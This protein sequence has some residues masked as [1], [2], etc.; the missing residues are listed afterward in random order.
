MKI[1]K[2]LGNEISKKVKSWKQIKEE[3]HELK[4][5][6]DAKDFDGNWED[7]FAISHTQVSSEPF[8]FF[9]LNK[10]KVKKFGSWCIVNLKIIKRAEESIFP[11]G[12]MSFM[13]RDMKKVDRWAH[14]TVTYWTP[15]W[16]LFLIPHRRKFKNLDAFIC[17]HED[18]HAHGINIYG[19]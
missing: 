6:I 13:H 14:I 16:N 10:I 15:L 2:P 1:R 11:E 12:C 5:F 18:D 8:N 17:Q 7:A 19:K 9:V 4:K 3:A